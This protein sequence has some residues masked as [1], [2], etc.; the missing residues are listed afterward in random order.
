MQIQ[1]T[2]PW[3]D[4]F[5]RRLTA[6]CCRQ[7]DVPVRVLKRAR[8]RQRHNEHRYSGRCWG[9]RILVSINPSPWVWPART[10]HAGETTVLADAI[11]A[12]VLVT[13]HEV[14]HTWQ[15]RVAR[16]IGHLIKTRRCERSAE[17]IA[18][19]TLAAFRADRPALLA[20]WGWAESPATPAPVATYEPEA[21]EEPETVGTPVR[22]AARTVRR[23]DPVAKL[24]AVE[25]KLVR[26]QRKLKTA[27]TYLKKYRR[28]Q[29]YYQRRLATEA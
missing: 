11:E 4:Q 26:W 25:A 3:P 2:T 28:Q 18:V 20:A 29:R 21:A 23:V 19:L 27:Q 16:N 1:N 6:W 14:G 7:A 8:F 10:E 22:V 12:L 17:R 5:L 9:S 15:F 13:A 24:A